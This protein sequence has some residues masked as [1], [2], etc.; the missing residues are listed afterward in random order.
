MID[1]LREHISK[2]LPSHRQNA[3]REYLQWLLL[4]AMD[5]GGYRRHLAFTGGTCLRLIF[6]TRRF[7][8]DLDFSLTHRRGYDT[9]ALQ[10]TLLQR[11]RRLGMRAEGSPVKDNKIVTSFFI[12]FEELLYLL[13]LSPQKTQKLSIKIEV[14]KNPPTGAK[15]EEFLFQDPVP[16]L[17][18][19]LDLP[20]L[21]ATKLHAFLFR[22]YD[23]GRDYYDLFFFLGRRVM[24]SLK[25]FQMAVRQTHPELIFST[26]SDLFDAV[27]RKLEG[28]NQKAVLRDVAP[29]LLLK[30]EERFLTKPILLKALDQFQSNFNLIPI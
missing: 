13:N 27:R 14:D 8:E 18:N 7:S 22:R 19:H 2:V 26:Y 11:I 1:V 5:D 9:F 24:P 28:M 10:E 29:F 15:V 30:S 20:S 6:K 12:H 21:F 3:L 25:L 17:V 23:K 4:Q 16:F